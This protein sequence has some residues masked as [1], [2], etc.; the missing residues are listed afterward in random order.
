MV[1]Q[2]LPAVNG[3]DGQWG[4]ILNQYL[5]KEHY[6]TGLDDPANGGHQTI[7]I[8]PGT[9][10]SGTAPLKFTSGPLTTMPEAGAVE[11]L[12]DKLYLTQTS[13]P[14]RKV[15]ATYNDS[16]GATGDTYYRDASGN[17]VRLAAGSTDQVLT[18]A[19]GLPSWAPPAPGGITRSVSA[20][21][22]P[23]TAGAATLTDYIYKVTTATT[24]TLPTAVGNTNLYTV[25]NAGSGAVSIATTSSQTIDGQA[26]PL[27]LQFTNSS[28]DLI[29]DNANW[30]IA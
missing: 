17:F 8:R 22:T 24:L 1:Q 19:G 11:F 21:S 20:I 18:I 28:V 9:T 25:K 16:A 26:S 23:T 10:A 15:I 7:T 30:R 2:R 27:V 29:S 12:T 6:D 5:T 14:T 4:D 13:G 3:D